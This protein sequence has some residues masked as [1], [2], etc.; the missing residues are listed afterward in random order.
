RTDNKEHI[1]FVANLTLYRY[2]PISDEL[3]QLTKPEDFFV[4][5]LTIDTDGK[6]WYANHLGLLTCVHSKQSINLNEVLDTKD[7]WVQQL[8]TDQQGYI[9]AGTKIGRASCRERGEHRVDN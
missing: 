2:T 1:W 7:I 5:A 9:L 4:S 6:A 3:Q 8:Y